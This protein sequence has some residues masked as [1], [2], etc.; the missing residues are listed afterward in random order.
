VTSQVPGVSKVA[1]LNVTPTGVAGPGQIPVTRTYPDQG[2]GRVAVTALPTGLTT[3]TPQ[4]LLAG[5][6]LQPDETGSVV[7][8]QLTHN[9]TVPGV[10]AGD[11]IQLVIGGLPTTWRVV[12]I[13]EERAGGGAYT[14]S[15][16]FAEAIGQPERVNQL[17][18][19]TAGDDERTRQAV[20]T[21]VTEP[22]TDAGIKVRSAASISRSEAI[23]EDHLTP[24]ILILLGIALPLGIVGVI[25][26]ASIMSTNILDRTREFGV[27]P[28]SEPAPRPSAASSPPR[29]SSWPSRAASQQS[30]RP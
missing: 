17:R 25:G 24:V 27:M 5:R 6:W 28:Q 15:E 16:G 2:H 22:L 12:G 21:A 29:A 11:S 10:R 4:K 26:L 23:T 20:A 14:T 7:L 3:F 19:F 9:N 18:I 13:V 30:S 8:N 1:A